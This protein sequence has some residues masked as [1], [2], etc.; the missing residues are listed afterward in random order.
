MKN[1]KKAAFFASFVFNKDAKEYLQ[2]ILLFINSLLSLAPLFNA[3][4]AK[5]AEFLSFLML[6]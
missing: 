4:S 3:K 1:Y 2:F 6:F 5:K